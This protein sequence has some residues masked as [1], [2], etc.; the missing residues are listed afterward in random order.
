MEKVEDLEDLEFWG[1]NGRMDQKALGILADAISDAGAWQWW[2]L[3][4]DMLQLEFCGVQL[5][6]ASKPE[7]D[8]H[9]MD[10]IAIRFYG[11][12]FAVFLDDLDEDA[13]RPWYER[14]HDDEIAA[15][16]CDGYE[17]EFDNPEYAKDVYDA[18]RNRTPITPFDGMNT[19]TGANHLIAAK[20]GD[21]GVIAGGDRIGLVNR[22]GAISEEEIEPMSRKWWEYWK[23]YWR[24]RGTRDALKTDPTCEVTIPVSRSDPQGMR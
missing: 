13:A 16:E 8:I 5:Y 9:T 6:D 19:L 1:G 12:V 10:V 24:L 14:F 3:E 17:L 23:Q 20:C 21:T 22:N 15:F 4:N 7:K 2:H 11:H 18:Y